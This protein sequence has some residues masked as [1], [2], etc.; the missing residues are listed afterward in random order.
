RQSFDGGGADTR[1]KSEWEAIVDRVLNSSRSSSALKIN[2]SINNGDTL[3]FSSLPP[4]TA[5][6][7]SEFT[8]ALVRD[9]VSH[10][11]NPIAPLDTSNSFPDACRAT[12]ARSFLKA[13]WHL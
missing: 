2:G 13:Y 7:M 11:Y 4:L 3:D 8:N 12:L 5:Q 10:W 6:A 1:G 9:Y